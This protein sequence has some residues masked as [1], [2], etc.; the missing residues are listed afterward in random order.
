MPT[1]AEV[2]DAAHSLW[3]LSGAEDWDA[4][5]LVAGDPSWSV[6]RVLIAVD[7]VA[8]TVDE[9]VDGNFDLLLSHH[10]LL[11]RGVT[12]VAADRY[13]GAALTRLISANCGL[14]AAHT[15]ADVVEAGTSA[16]LADRLGLTQQRVILPSETEGHGL[17]RIGELSEPMHLGE[18]A[19]TLSRVLPATA[20]GIRVAGTWNQQVQTVAVCAGA[21][22]SL[23]DHP[24]VRAAD[25]FV[26]A[27][28]RHHPAQESR[29]QSMLA[30][31]PALLDVSHWASEWVWCEVAGQQLRRTLPGVEI[32]VSE[33]RTDPWDFVVLAHPEGLA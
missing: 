1:L 24:E 20:G 25:A 17:G 4:P 32:V 6:S 10:P 11:L 21:G 9:A 2:V 14:L 16:I 30:G 3:P 5:G 12:S 23:L 18:L 28:L 8:A 29:E 13:K 27:D 19:R 26:T 31:G 22:D 7:A 15:N 33:L